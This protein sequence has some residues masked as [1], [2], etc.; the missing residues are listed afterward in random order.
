M[1]CYLCD[2]SGQPTEAVAVCRHC[3]LALCRDHVDEALLAERPAGLARPGCIHNPIG[4]ARVRRDIQ[5][6]EALL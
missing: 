1:H 6:L 2:S 5:E 3:G 4:W